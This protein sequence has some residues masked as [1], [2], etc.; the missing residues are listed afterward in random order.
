MKVCILGDTCGKTSIVQRW[1]QPHVPIHDETTIGIDMKTLS[2]VFDNQ[3]RRVQLWDCSGESFYKNLLDTYILNSAVVVICFD[4][5]SDTSFQTAQYWATRVKGV[6]SDTTICF[7]G[8]KL[9]LESRRMVKEKN[10]KRYIKKLTFDHVFYS[11]CSAYT[12]ENCRNT[13]HLIIREGSRTRDTYDINDFKPVEQ[14]SGCTI[15]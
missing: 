15:A 11:E 2:L 4:L 12:G 14:K 9:D 5:T 3:V 7:I 10:I 6:S 8:T 1:I 13:L